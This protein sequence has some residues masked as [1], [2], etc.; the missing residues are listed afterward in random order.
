[1]KDEIKLA[2]H[3]NNP[4]I[5]CHTLLSVENWSRLLASDEKFM[6]TLNEW[7]HHK[8]EVR[9]HS[10]SHGDSC[11]RSPV[12]KGYEHFYYNVDHQMYVSYNMEITRSLNAIE[13]RKFGRDCRGISKSMDIPLSMWATVLRAD[14]QSRRKYKKEVCPCCKK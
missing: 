10:L 1:M 2:T 13:R 11:I 12:D 3:L 5:T 9:I 6:K 7:S 8:L 14:T 4:R